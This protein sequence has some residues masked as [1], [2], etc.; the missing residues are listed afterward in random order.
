MESKEDI[1]ARLRTQYPGPLTRQQGNQVIE[2]TPEEK[3]QKLSEW[4]DAEI[5]RQ[6]EFPEGTKIWPGASEFLDEMTIEEQAAIANH[7][8]LAGLALQLAAWRG[9]VR[10]T[11]PRIVEGL[12]ACVAAG[13]LTQQR[14]DEIVA[15]D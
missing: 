9:A 4:A 3:E 13:V 14:I 1:L 15:V 5:E 2:L 6:E 10:S 8:E 11:A 12:A 7:P